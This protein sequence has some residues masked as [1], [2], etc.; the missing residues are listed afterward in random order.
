MTSILLNI[1]KGTKEILGNHADYDNN[2][3]LFLTYFKQIE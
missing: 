1:K 3:T 2:D